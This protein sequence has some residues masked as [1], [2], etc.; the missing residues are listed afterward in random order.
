MSRKKRAIENPKAEDPLE[1]EDRGKRLV[2][3]QRHGKVVESREDEV[4]AWVDLLVDWEKKS[5]EGSS[6]L[7]RRK[8]SK[9][10]RFMFRKR[11]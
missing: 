8:K 10:Q 6:G 4:R 9:R 1:G 3:L 7:S 11:E 2:T 5:E